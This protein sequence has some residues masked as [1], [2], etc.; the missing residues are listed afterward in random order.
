MTVDELIEAA[1][2][3]LL[4]SDKV[5]AAIRGGGTVPPEVEKPKTTRKPKESNPDPEP[6]VDFDDDIPF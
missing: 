1:R 2:E 6:A 4:L 3:V 5:A